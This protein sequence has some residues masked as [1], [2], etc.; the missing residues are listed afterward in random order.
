MPDYIQLNKPAFPSGPFVGNGDVSFIYA[1]NGTNYVKKH[2]DGSMDWQQWLYMSKND[3]W[4]SDSKSYYPHLSAGRV[5]LLATHPSSGTVVNGTVHMFPG[6]ASIVHSLIDSA[7]EASVTATTRVLENNVIVTTLVC[8]S[9]LGS[10][11]S[12]TLLLS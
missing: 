12:A 1:G 10:A 4:G 5:G 3:M 8:A 11:C 2:I 9:K 7:G 6:N